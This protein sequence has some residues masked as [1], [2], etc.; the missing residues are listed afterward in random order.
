[1]TIHDPALVTRH[2]GDLQELY[3]RSI[4]TWVRGFLILGIISLFGLYGASY[5]DNART[6]STKEEMK[7]LRQELKEMRIEIRQDLKELSGKLEPAQPRL[8]K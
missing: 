5:V 6:Y 8:T 4:P 1:M 2:E 7:D 3:K